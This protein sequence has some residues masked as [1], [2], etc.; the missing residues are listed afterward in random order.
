MVRWALHFPS[1][2]GLFGEW[3]LGVGELFLFL[4][5]LFVFFALAGGLFLV[6][7]VV[8]LADELVF[9]AGLIIHNSKIVQYSFCNNNKIVINSEDS[10]LAPSATGTL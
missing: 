5:V 9:K 7:F 2:F 8:L 3:L 10:S 1:K 6:N 4:L